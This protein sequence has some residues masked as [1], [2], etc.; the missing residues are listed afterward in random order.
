[1]SLYRD[2]RLPM[3]ICHIHVSCPGS[4]N[5]NICHSSLHLSSR[6]LVHALNRCWNCLWNSYH[7]SNNISHNLKAS[8]FCSCLDIDPHSQTFQSPLHLSNSIETVLSS[9]RHWPRY[10]PHALQPFHI[11]IIPHMNPL[12]GPPMRLIHVWGRLAINPHSTIHLATSI[13]PLLL[14]FHSHNDPGKYN[15]YWIF[16]DL[17]HV[18]SR[19]PRFL[20]KYDHYCTTSAL[21]HVSSHLCTNHNM[22]HSYIF[23]ILNAQ[24]AVV[25]FCL[26]K[27]VHIFR[28]TAIVP[29]S[30]CSATQWIL[31][32]KWLMQFVVVKSFVIN[33]NS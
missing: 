24:S 30:C 14:V 8:L 4:T 1:M 25:P 23:S 27:K 31:L 11:S 17:C 29:S 19:P 7:Y 2:C 18:C 12:L 13:S 21:D 15:Y 9:D 32:W 6:F 26:W 28:S 22:W 3:W 10:E 16:H 5:P 20:R 33:F